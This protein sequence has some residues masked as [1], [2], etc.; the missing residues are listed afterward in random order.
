MDGHP[1]NLPIPRPIHQRTP[2]IPP[3]SAPRACGSKGDPPIRITRRGKGEP[4]FPVQD[5]VH[6]EGAEY[7]S[8]S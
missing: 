8:T 5:L 7:T 4:P 2:L 6:W 3:R 1:P